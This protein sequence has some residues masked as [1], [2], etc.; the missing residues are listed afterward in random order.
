MKRKLSNIEAQIEELKKY[1]EQNKNIVALYIFGSYG[2]DRQH[3]SSDIDF[4]ILYKNSP[5]LFDGLR[6]ESDISQIFERDDIDLVNLNK[7]PIDICHQVLY[8]GNLLHCNDAIA[9]ADFKENVF[10]IYGDYG[11]ILKMFYDDYME[12]LRAKYDRN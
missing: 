9:L 3:I 11:I 5:S 10:K 1:I 8:T 6:I 12:G 4:A 2:T 7:A